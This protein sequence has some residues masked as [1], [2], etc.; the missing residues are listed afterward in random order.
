MAGGGTV[1]QDAREAA[2]RLRESLLGEE[3]NEG[4]PA[5]RLVTSALRTSGLRYQLRRSSD[6][7]LSGAHAVLDMEVKAVWVRADATHAERPVFI[8]HELAHLHLHH[9]DHEE[10]GMCHCSAPD[11]QE[12]DMLVG[13]GYGPRQR[14]ETEANAFAREFLLPATL[15]HRL[16]ND[17]LTA[18]QIAERVGVPLPVVYTQLENAWHK[19]LS[20]TDAQNSP[21]PPKTPPD[22]TSSQRRSLSSPE[23]SGGGTGGG[24]WYLLDPSQKAAATATHGPLLVVAGPGTGKTRTLVARV[25]HLVREQGV[26]P[27]NLLLVTFTRKTVAEMRERLA[28]I[29][30][31]IA[32]RVAIHTY[33]SFGLD[34]LR[35]QG[36]AAGLPPVP[37]L[38]EKMDAVLLLEQRAALMELGALRYLHD[39]SY[40]LPHVHD[41]ITRAKD[42]MWTPADYAAKAAETGD[43]RLED[44]ARIFATYEGLLRECG[45]LDYSDLVVR[46]VRLLEENDAVREAER[47]QWQHILVD[48]YQDIN[49]SGARL[50]KALAG[51]G[52]G[53]WVVGDI[54]QAIYAWRGAT[55]ECVSQFE[56]DYPA[57]RRMELAVNY[58]SRPGLVALFGIASG[59][60]ADKWAS[61]RAN[62]GEP[63][64]TMSLAI[65]GNET[66]Q[67]EGIARKIQEFAGMGYAFRDVAILCRARRQAR[68]LRAALVERGIPVIVPPAENGLLATPEVREMVALLDRAV[69][70]TGPSRHRFPELPPGLPFKGDALD[71][72]CELLWGDPAWA[73][74]IQDFEAVRYLL[75]LA[76]A[77]RERAVVLLNH[78]DDPRRSFLRHLRRIAQMAPDVGESEEEEAPNAVRVMTAHSA[79]GLEF[80]IVFVPNLAQDMF[81]IRPR[82][83]FLPSLTDDGA[84]GMSEEQRL[85]FVALTRARDHL[86]LTRPE[87]IYKNQRHADASPLLGAVQNAPLTREEWPAPRPPRRFEDVPTPPEDTVLGEKPT[88]TADE[89]NLYLRC[90]RRYYYER[91]AE[92][93]SGEFSPYVRF[94][95]SV[96][97]AL[98]GSDPMA[99]F[100]FAWDRH[101][102]EETHPFT[103]LYRAEAEKIVARE[104]EKG[105][106][107]PSYRPSESMSRV[108]G[109]GSRPDLPTL[110]LTLP[111]G[112]VTVQPD[113]VDAVANEYEIQSFRKPP[114]TGADV[115]VDGDGTPY[116]VQEIARR[117]PANPTAPPAT[118]RIRFMQSGESFPLV[119]KP[120]EREK[121]VKAYDGALRGIRLQMY[122][123]APK[124]PMEECPACPYYFICPE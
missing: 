31:E 21:P 15:A 12:S 49:R 37:I 115:K 106:A 121:H 92:V 10:S 77:F 23:G 51:E 122:Q 4:I 2:R 62:S 34:L 11:F 86:V 58:R 66:A 32:R 3:A 57:G 75:G 119:D 29:D 30:P 64:A 54:R 27:E 19:A 28:A 17:G 18:R 35:R 13:A 40:P 55:P 107:F 88:L 1:W 63:G 41:A 65:A 38:L 97:A 42:E 99:E 108:R 95:R 50:I 36:G 44:A 80:P 52:K 94:R 112:T 48:E 93:P 9:A 73:R 82:P 56:K 114:E 7:L 96:R 26:A 89:A 68:N 16:F 72:W 83:S 109:R 110:S 124:D 60:G 123:P 71:F 70:P 39:P 84:E 8:A 104:A 102:P 90:P 81:P 67:A 79:K 87:R 69:D 76:R 74:R 43:A 59:E 116:L 113:T 53:L 101:G 85:F 45:A 14:R 118:V 103:P 105:T 120:R 47:A 22:V 33:H 61:A 117:A 46:A 25:I 24:E 78:R 6:P 91:V 111:N 20:T 100:E 98:A 5:L